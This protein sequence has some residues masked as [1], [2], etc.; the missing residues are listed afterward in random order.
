MIKKDGGKT[1]RG[2]GAGTAHH[3]AQEARG[4]R[5]ASAGPSAPNKGKTASANGQRQRGAKKKLP[6]IA[7]L[8][9]EEPREGPGRP[10]E[11]R[12]EFVRVAHGMAKLG[13]TDF[14]IAEELGISTSTLWRWR[15]LY[16][17]FSSALLEG[18]GQFDERAERSLAQKAIGYSYHS[19]KVFCH[20]GQ[21]IRA[22]IVEHVP[23][24]VGAIKLWL[25]NRRPDKWR[26]KQEV[27][28]DG[29][30]A[31]LACWQAISEGRA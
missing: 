29:S 17:E 31:F 20:D 10:I 8:G 28:L 14:E 13:G 24:D 3:G 5:K 12:P 1:S 19:E 11:Y 23:P 9:I 4:A 2:G 26:D 15:S 22:E 16:P 6:P 18:K 30:D 25:G 21:I 7:A 27:K